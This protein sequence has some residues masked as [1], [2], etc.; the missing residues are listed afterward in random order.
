MIYVKSCL[1]PVEFHTLSQYGE[2]V[3]CQIND[4]LV[5][6]CYRSTNE[7]IV[8][9]DNESKLYNV[10]QEVS[11]KFMLLMGDFNYADIDWPIHSVSSSAS[12][13]SNEIFK[14]VEEHFL[15]QHVNSPTRGDAILDLVL[16]SE[17]DLISNVTVIHNFRNSD[18]NMVAFTT[19]LQCQS[20]NNMRTFRDY[21]Q[22]DYESINS[23]L[24]SVNWNEFLNGDTACCWSRF[25]NLLHE[26]EDKFVPVKRICEQTANKKACLDVT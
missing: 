8:G 6:V 12:S 22:G 10:L 1:K 19:H 7:A 24:A 21:K 13:G 15:T 14:L 25:S 2:H 18:H 23:A 17:P 3:W 16:S 5:G 20:F 11:N 26:L 4:L 9:N